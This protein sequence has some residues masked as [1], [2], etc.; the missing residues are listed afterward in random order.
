MERSVGIYQ[1]TYLV[2]IGVSGLTAMLYT[3]LGIVILKVLNSIGIHQ[4][5]FLSLEIWLYGEGAF[6]NGVGHTAVVIGPSTKSYVVCVD[7]NWIGANS[8][9]GSPAAK[10][11]HTYNGIS[12][13]V[14]PAYHP[15]TKNHR[16]QVVHRLNPLTTT[17]LK[18]QKNKRNL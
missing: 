1:I 2:G 3:W 5:L 12:G 17:L 10:I 7:Q 15:E 18:I 4:I 11:K 9:T 6:N 14:R 8:Y 13:F 16:N